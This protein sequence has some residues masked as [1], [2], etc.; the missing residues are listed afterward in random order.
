LVREGPSIEG[1][2]GVGGDVD[3]SG[4]PTGEGAGAAA[5]FLVCAE[6]IAI[7]DCGSGGRLI[8]RG[9]EGGTVGGGGVGVNS[10]KLLT[11][12]RDTDDTKPERLASRATSKARQHVAA[13]RPAPKRCD[14]AGDRPSPVPR[15][16]I[17]DF[18][19]E[20]IV[21]RTRS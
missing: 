13:A 21:V 3:D 17:K 11:S 9:R 18:R 2:K 19:S 14:K 10:V 5:C 4:A 15:P 1:I 12:R 16:C 8:S 7:P 6:A 20:R